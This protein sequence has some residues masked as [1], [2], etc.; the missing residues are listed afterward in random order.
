MNLVHRDAIYM[1]NS[2]AMKEHAFVIFKEP[3]F[4]LRAASGCLNA[5]FQ[6]EQIHNSQP[7]QDRL[8]SIMH[9]KR[10]IFQNICRDA[11]NPPSPKN[12]R[13]DQ[14]DPES[15]QT[16]RS[17][18]RGGRA[19][20]TSGSEGMNDFIKPFELGG[21]ASDSMQ[22]HDI[23]EW[24]GRTGTRR[25]MA[26]PSATTAENWLRTEERYVTDAP[27]LGHENQ[28]TIVDSLPKVASGIT[29]SPRLSRSED[30]Q[31]K[32]NLLIAAAMAN[33]DKD[34]SS[35]VTI[36]P[37]RCALPAA[38]PVPTPGHE[39]CG[40]QPSSVCNDS[41]LLRPNFPS[42]SIGTSSAACPQ[43]K[44]QRTKKAPTQPRAHPLPLKPSS[45]TPS[46][47]ISV[48]SLSPPIQSTNVSISSL[49][50]DA[51]PFSPTS[52]KL[53]ERFIPER[54]L[55]SQPYRDEVPTTVDLIRGAYIEDPLE[56][57]RYA[58]VLIMKNANEGLYDLAEAIGT[59][60]LDSV[61]KF[62]ANTRCGL[63]VKNV[64]LALANV[65]I[66][67]ARRAMGPE[68]EGFMKAAARYIDLAENDFSPPISLNLI[69]LSMLAAEKP[70]APLSPP[71]P[72]ESNSSLKEAPSLGSSL[73]ASPRNGR[74]PFGSDT[75]QAHVAFVES[76]Y[77][78]TTAQLGKEQSSKRKAEELLHEEKAKRRCIEKEMDTILDEKMQLEQALKDERAR[79]RKAE[80]D[81]WDSRK[82]PVYGTQTTPSSAPLLIFSVFKT[83]T[84]QEVV[85]ELK[86]D[87]CITGV[88]KSV[89][90]FLN[91]RLDAI[92]VMDEARHPHMMAVK[93]CFI[94]GSVVR[95]VQLP[96][97]GVDTNLLEDATR[98]EAQNQ[99]KK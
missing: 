67:R 52:F 51:M 28:S 73:P 29:T 76:L 68:Q 91:I 71:A 6:C 62:E 34:N 45:S 4:A 55:G 38:L 63:S 22:T 64:Y 99:V 27:E 11:T 56:A 35:K 20:S 75:L 47:S 14:C 40:M 24:R 1:W 83:L 19:I 8:Q 50:S 95:Y 54:A 74:K 49:A 66:R 77:S 30:L 80:D 37:L 85:V 48:S 10:Q 33:M 31:T 86:N 59:Q 21:L 39:S 3:E 42:L 16:K 5:S 32:L 41:G 13:R 46:Q 12:S 58:C 88:L 96:P 18:E 97:S 79:R 98:R 60:C 90:Q 7:L 9:E 78:N 36:T 26:S 72:P 92:K 53:P 84:D 87:L 17:S 25:V 23:D 82:Y 93:N 15:P 70:T 69:R 44:P 89:D 61:R 81:A 65:K 2:P 57:H 94:R 43:Q